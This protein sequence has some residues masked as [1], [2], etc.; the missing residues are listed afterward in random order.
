MERLTIWNE[1]ND[2]NAFKKKLKSRNKLKNDFSFIKDN[3]TIS[4]KRMIHLLLRY[5]F[6]FLVLNV[7]RLVE[8]NC[9][10]VSAPWSCRPFNLQNK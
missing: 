1:T 8:F 9:R 4:S 2:R 3:I 5:F 6:L 10:S 7:T